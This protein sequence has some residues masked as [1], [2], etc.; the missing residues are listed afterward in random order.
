MDVDEHDVKAEVP[1]R[2]EPDP[3]LAEREVLEGVIE[4][5]P[6]RLTV[7]EL[8]QK[9]TSGSQEKWRVERA[10][11][12]IRELKGWGLLRY[13]DDDQL[14]EPTPAAVH[15]SELFNSMT[16]QGWW[17]PDPQTRWHLSYYPRLHHD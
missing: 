13:R 8:C 4:L 2:A 15:F 3:E 10:R 1:I 6:V 11:N 16:G 12:A 14:V 5:L 9:I 17:G 7:S